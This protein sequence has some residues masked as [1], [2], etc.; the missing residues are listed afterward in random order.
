MPWPRLGRRGRHGL[1]AHL[2]GLDDV[3]VARAAAQVAVQQ[4]A[5]LGLA[6]LGVVLAQVDG[7][8]HHARGA[9]AALQ[10]VA[11]L[12][13]RLH[14]MQRAVGL[15]DALDGGDLGAGHL[16]HQHVAGLDRAAVDVDRAGAALRGVAAHVRARQLEVLADRLHEEGV[17]GRIDRDR[18]AVDR[19]WNLHV[20]VSVLVMAEATGMLDAGPG[21]HPRQNPRRLRVVLEILKMKQPAARAG[22]RHASMATPLHHDEHTF[23]APA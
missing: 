15:R 6:G 18:A 16:G 7:A 4:L 2:H 8:H 22:R 11:L 19:E 9:E 21:H 12:E 10:A 14:R 3:L 20:A 13:G 1:A 17:G 23:N 5:D